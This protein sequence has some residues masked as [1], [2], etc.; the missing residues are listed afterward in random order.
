M[1]KSL[2]SFGLAL[3]CAASTALAQATATATVTVGAE[4]GLTVSAT[5]PLT[6]SGGPFGPFTGTTNLMY[7]VRTSQ[8]SGSSSIVAKVTSDFSPINGP[9]A[10]AGDLKYTCAVSAPGSGGTA[11]PCSGLIVASP[12]NPTAVASFGPDARSSI[13]GNSASV[14]WTLNNSPSF[15][16]GS[17]SA[18]VTF[19]ISA[20]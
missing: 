15:K 13:T 11:T 20:N 8:G 17:Y 10:G 3:L 5:P 14:Q 6:K 2:A 19:T 1:K 4:A 18:T 7:Y 9:S 12:G 16:A